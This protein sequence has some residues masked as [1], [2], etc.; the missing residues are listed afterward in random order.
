MWHHF[1]KEKFLPVY[2]SGKVNIADL[3]TKPLPRD[4]MRNFTIDLGLDKPKEV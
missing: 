4:T 1:V 3:L 2:I